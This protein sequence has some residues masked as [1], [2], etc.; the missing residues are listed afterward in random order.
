MVH[1][2]HIKIKSFERQIKLS[3]FEAFFKQNRQTYH[4]SLLKKKQFRSLEKIS[5]V[6]INKIKS[7]VQKISPL[8]PIF[9][10]RNNLDLDKYLSSNPQDLR[11]LRTKALSTNK[12]QRIH[13]IYNSIIKEFL[14]KICLI[15]P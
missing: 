12:L 3:L 1:Q 13:V 2:R 7:K 5:L 15:K 10:V 14:I 6:Q 9:Q 4:C 8:I 11:N